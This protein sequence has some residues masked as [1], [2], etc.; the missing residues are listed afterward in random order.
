[1]NIHD[2]R[3]DPSGTFASIYAAETMRWSQSLHWDTRLNWLEVEAARL[4][5]RLP[6]LVARDAAGSICGWTFYLL[7]NGVLEI[8]ALQSTSARV[9][10]AL[11][12]GAQASA[13]GADAS[14]VVLFAHSEAPGLA[15]QLQAR[16][17]AVGR[18]LYLSALL[19]DMA[20]ADRAE[21][22]DLRLY[23]QARDRAGVADL[24][25]AAYSHDDR[26]R[27]FVRSGR[28]HEWAAYLGQ[29]LTT[30]GCGTFLPAA[31]FVAAVA[32]AARLHGATL[33]SRLAADTVHLAQVVVRPEAQGAGLARGLI[34]ASLQAASQ[35]GFSR[36][37]LLVG[38]GNGRAR[39]LYAHLGFAPVSGFV[40]A[41]FDHPRRSSRVALESGGAMTLR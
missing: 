15:A 41:I 12:A 29:L 40:S 34:A 3:S 6:G 37:T 35:Q 33:V 38:E 5:G 4:A 25:A 1:V 22:V 32:P 13:D 24:L 7:H 23:D 28:P 16:G 20:T 30:T 17:F 9:T 31:S 11:I 19:G 36:A 2:W 14:S 27:P 18:Y 26:A 21:P 39:R 8:G 10:G